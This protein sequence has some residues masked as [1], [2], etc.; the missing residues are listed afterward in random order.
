MV[1][2]IP[3]LQRD[4]FQLLCQYWKLSDAEHPTSKDISFTN[5]HG[6]LFE[7]GIVFLTDSSLLENPAGEMSYG[8]FRLNGNKIEANFDNGKKAVYTM[9]RLHK[10]EL[11]LDRL[12][13]K[14]T[15]ELTY[16]STDTW[17]PDANKNPFAK[18]NYQW[19]IKPK[20][21]ESD[22]EI[23]KRL[24]EFVQFYKYYFDGLVKGGATNIDFTGL[25]GCL[26]WY[27]GGITIQ[28]ENKLDKKWIN[29]FYSTEQAYKGRQML[30]DVLVK[31]YDWDTKE[32]NWLK[33]TA[34]VLQQIYDGM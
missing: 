8:K 34:S 15:S 29:C 17:W 4:S 13:N 22:Q 28:S 16:K 3:T 20:K 2:T 24:K 18:Q 5:D 30:E 21:A 31:K 19:S 33:Q 23:K 1:H 26:N 14:H 32:T 25:P 10:D 6:I 11:L 7:S 9:N 27:Q 12:E